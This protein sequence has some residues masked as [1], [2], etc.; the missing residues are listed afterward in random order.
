MVWGAILGS[1]I[2]TGGSLLG[3]YLNR[4]AASAAR[5]DY[6]RNAQLDRDLQREFAQFGIRWR[7]RDA[8]KAGI[9]PLFALGGNTATYTPTASYIPADT[10][11]G[12]SIG[13][14]LSRFGQNIGRAI[15]ATRTARERQTARL[16]ELQV[17]NAEADW[18]TKS[19]QNDLLRSEISRLNAPQI[20]PP[21][22]SAV[23]Q[24]AIPGQVDV[25]PLA[26]LA[27]YE[28]S[29]VEV[30]AVQSTRPNQEAGAFPETRWARTQSGWQPLPSREAYE[31][32]DLANPS[33]WS[34]YWRNQA[35]PT[36]G[37]GGSAPP[38]SWLPKYA[39]G[40]VWHPMLQEWQPHFGEPNWARS[41]WFQ[42]RRR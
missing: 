38:D 8:Q 32:A 11:M 20:P 15:D 25:E 24:S 21:M 41:I 37:Q 5:G 16:S 30:P 40:W 10:S 22:P 2:S 31:D 19:L 39:T 35:L 3:G 42:R 36:L 17:L 12:D 28:V 29:P 23:P 18:E 7:V 6:L 4:S 34:W 9:H 13:G 14:S 27:G 1:A 26:P 33:A